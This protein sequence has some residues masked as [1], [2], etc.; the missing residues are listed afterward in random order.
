M[1]RPPIPEASRRRLA[2]V[3]DKLAGLLP[4]S[5]DVGVVRRSRDGGDIELTAP[6]GS[7][8]TVT[9]V[10]RRRLE[11]RDA[12][13]LSPSED[14]VIAFADWLSPRTREVLL[15]RGANFIDGTGNTDVRLDRPAVTIRTDGA[16]RDPD[17]KPRPRGPSLDGP[18]AWA[19]MRTLVEVEPPYTAGELAAALGM[20]D[21]YVSRILKVL[22]EELM[23]EREP[24]QP[25]TAVGWEKIV[26]QITNDY[27][28]L[29]SNETATWTAMG[30]PA[31]FLRDLAAKPP[32]RYALTGSF[33]SIETVAVTAPTVA[34]VY[35]D[36]PERLAK[37][38][39]LRP[40]RTGGNVITAIPYDPIVYER[41]R[42]I[43]GVEHASIAQVAI[44]CLAGMQRMPSEGEALLKWMK[45]NE[46][47]SR[48][49][50]LIDNTGPR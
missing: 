6:D 32:K 7:T 49:R 18:R 41:T 29:S 1:G 36:D 16:R 33:S 22:T 8:G 43:G 34:V 47:Q 28:L 10:A 17:P 30:G 39:R 21:G 40:T 27:R 19:L 31:Q 26:R 2:I 24:R 23:I 3:A 46:P 11:P 37:D 48:S 45:Q 25:V 50:T 9:V 44:D 38:Y 13:K 35:T 5:W 42:T 12:V 15:E 14:P 20:D 4:A